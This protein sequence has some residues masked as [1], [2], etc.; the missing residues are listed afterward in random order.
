MADNTFLGLQPYTEDDAYRFK[1]RAEESQE[2]YRLIARNDFT[3]C[4][5]ES[6]EG[7]TS[8]LNA[9]VFPLLRENMY[10]PIAITFTS[11]DYQ[12]TPD[13]FDTII[14]RCIKDSITE[15]NEKNKGVNV[16]YRFCSSDFQGLDC[17]AELQQALSKYS[18]WK[19]RNYKPQTM[20]LTF[21][22]V[23]VFDQFEEVFNMPGSIVWTKKFFDWLEDV[24]S[25]SCPDEIAKKVRDVIG[26]NAAFP[27]IKE[28]KDFKAV[29]SLRKEF[30]GE[31]DYWGM[32][33]CF[34][35]S[36][37]NNRY[38]LK[39]LTY[40]GAK[41][42]MTQ[43]ERFDESKV[44]QV[45][46]HF[47]KQHSREPE[48]TIKEHLPIIPALML[49]IVC[50]GWEKDID[51][52]AQLSTAEIGQSLTT[53]LES[54]FNQAIDTIVQELSKQLPNTNPSQCRYDLDTSV[55][56]LVDGNG[57]RV[58]TKTTNA[59]LV[60]INFDARY[61][62]ALSSQRIIKITK[63]DGEDYVEIVHDCLCP[64]VAKQKEERHT[65]EAKEIE[66][67]KL[68]LLRKR[69]RRILRASAIFVFL[70]FIVVAIVL[71]Q[72][73]KADAAN[74]KMQENQA[75]F[76][77][78]KAMK[79][80]DEGDCYLSRLL[81]IKVLPT[82]VDSDNPDRP[83]TPEAEGALRNA[84]M[85]D[86][87]ILKGHTSYVTSAVFNHDGTKIVSASD[88]RTIR[89]WDVKTG[90]Q[91]GEPLKGHTDGIISASFN[92]DGT[93]I[94]SMLDDGRVKVWDRG[95][96][97]H[98]E[99]TLKGHTGEIKFAS[100][101][102]DGT[103]IAL[104]SKDNT[105]KVWDI[106]K[107]EQIGTSLKEP[108]GK[109][110]S[111]TFNH[112]GTKIIFV[113]DGSRVKIWDR[114]T[115]KHAEKTLKGHTGEI[116]FASFNH[117]ETK[118]V[119]VSDD[120]TIK[121]WDVKTGK[122]LERSLEGH[123][124]KVNTV[125]FNHDGTR[126]VS[127]ANDNTIRIWDV[128]T[129]KQ[130]VRSLEGLK[131]IFNAVTFNHDGT[132]IVSVLDDNTIRIWNVKT[133][134]QIGESLKG[135]EGKVNTVA[136]NHDGTRIVS[137]AD[138]N[139]IRIWNAKTGK[140]IGEP[141]KGHWSKVQA[142]HGVTIRYWYANATSSASI[143][144]GPDISSVPDDNI[145]KTKE[146]KAGKQIVASLKS[147]E[148]GICSASFNH[149][150]TKIV[151]THKDNTIRFWDVKTREQIGLPLKVGQGKFIKSV[152]FNHDGTKIVSASDDNTIRIW[153]V[154]TGKQIGKP[155]LRHSGKVNSVSFNHDGTKIVSVLDD[156]T[157][158][159]WDVKTRGQIVKPLLG[160]ENKIILASF[161]PDGTKI[162][163]ASVDG[164]VK[165]W[166]EKSG[167]LIVQLQLEHAG[168]IGCVAF[169][170]DNTKIISARYD[171]SIRMWDY[172]PLQ[173]LIDETRERFK[174]RQLTDEERQMYYLED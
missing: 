12:V 28:E 58:R 110:N 161:N 114:E 137:A 142:A 150:G 100:F 68:Q 139:T 138:D 46:T 164:V 132:K 119:L 45:L 5:A 31:L 14:D 18:W 40:E 96:G 6:G 104:V 116:K 13:N 95:T 158:R 120:N 84:L 99:K 156:N 92:C 102:H 166:D 101:N 59:A 19:L 122:Q 126:V 152:S 26:T 172:R 25:D 44:E 38:C 167:R 51:T 147:N 11:D 130:I 42:V 21:T 4:Y 90:K 118:I 169:N 117:D 170:H 53:V 76:I 146:I 37:K 128:K 69:N 48:Q 35:P 70:A 135:H 141:F 49:S 125:T 17:Q 85:K 54:F 123:A 67:R 86:N 134:K 2:L 115:G 23:F 112:D 162:I 50:D 149:D 103:K 61:K 80:A 65:R 56:A 3:V 77:A 1:G 168:G 74:W 140:Q 157:I 131:R 9:G 153:S 174:E 155:L 16:E 34:I 32:Q 113:I 160:H 151:S 145:T 88:D 78:E 55:F 62:Q 124:G 7:K 165:I 109:V 89:I 39:A 144:K 75:R 72:K 171:G 30:I 20:G 8:L 36:L 91:I 136:F 43:Q 163:S 173:E 15:Y 87:A 107:G 154:K 98:T 27:A 143:H 106:E 79:L 82:D 63:V 148:D 93:K 22:P 73:H 105:I 111:V 71:F 121:I 66:V 133:G 97:K 10:F 24:A 33:K 108:V 83:Y 127:A 47:V 52:F 129:D 60:Q 57:K 159:I 94:V 81:A 41:K 64:I 29:F